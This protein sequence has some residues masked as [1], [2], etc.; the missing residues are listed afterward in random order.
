MGQGRSDAPGILAQ[1]PEH[2]H[3]AERARQAGGEDQLR[4]EPAV[5]AVMLRQVEVHTASSED[6]DRRSAFP[7]QR[8]MSANTSSARAMPAST[9]PD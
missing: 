8:Y 6:L 5:A 2:R 9:S 7:V 3:D 1:Q 4:G